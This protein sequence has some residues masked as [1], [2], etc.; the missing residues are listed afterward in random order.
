MLPRR[1]LQNIADCIRAPLNFLMSGEVLFCVGSKVRS[2]QK[3]EDTPIHAPSTCSRYGILSPAPR[4][5]GGECTKSLN[6]VKGKTTDNQQKNRSWCCCPVQH[7]LK[8]SQ[9]ARCVPKILSPQ[10]PQASCEDP[11]SIQGSVEKLGP[12]IR[13][14]SFLLPMACTQGTRLERQHFRATECFDENFTLSGVTTWH[15]GHELTM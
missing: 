10:S 3:P 8:G 13:R 6:S 15:P 4:F 9:N 5:H 7:D 2:C 12:D 11:R 14:P 1:A